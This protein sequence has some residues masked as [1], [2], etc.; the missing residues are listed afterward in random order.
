MRSSLVLALL[1]SA[2]AS[3]APTDRL[4][5]EQGAAERARDALATKL[6]ERD[7]AMVSRVRALY[8]LTRA[9]DAP[10]WAVGPDR[11][12]AFRQ[13]EAARRV[14]LRDLEER[15]RIA[16]DWSA[17]T[18]A[19]TRLAAASA[20]VRFVRAPLPRG[21]WVRPVPGRIAKPFG[22]FVDPETRARFD[23]PVVELVAR[24]GWNVVAPR[25]GKILF[26]GSTRAGQ[27]LLVEHDRDLV[28][29]LLGAVPV[30]APGTVVAAGQVIGRA[31][32]ER[33]GVSLRQGGRPIDPAALWP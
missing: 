12:A 6:A 10:A 24:P 17:A 15:R 22:P 9:A 30:V 19:A 26:T 5:V 8:K 11:A 13:Q 18:A 7:R 32:G 21:G 27:V 14:I 1:V 29:V 25:G 31:T 3:A 2:T 28:T 33:L 4:A 23:R 20:W 16:D